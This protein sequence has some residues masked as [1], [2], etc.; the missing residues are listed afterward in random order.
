MSLNPLSA[1]FKKWGFS[2]R[3]II[4]NKNGEWLLFLQIILILSN[5]IPSWPNK[6]LSSSINSYL[7]ILGVTI[8][9]SGLGIAMKSIKDLGKQL[10]PLPEPMKGSRLVRNGIYFHIRHPLY[11]AI[12]TISIGISISLSSLLHLFLAIALII[13]LKIKAI[14]EEKRLK[15]I[16]RDYIS[17]MSTTPAILPGISFLD[18][19]K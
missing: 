4:D 6:F 9:L 19:R 15:T 18:W 12:I 3:G 8:S 7:T 14:R 17:Y 16:H 5:L 10:T 1:L 2:W 11:L 13:T